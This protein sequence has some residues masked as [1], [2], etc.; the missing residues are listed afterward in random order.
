MPSLPVLLAW[1]FVLMLLLYAYP[2]NNFLFRT[3]FLVSIFL[4][5]FCLW[6]VLWKRKLLFWIV[7]I[8]L[9]SYWSILVF[10]SKSEKSTL[11][12][13][14]YL[15]QIASFEWTRYVWWGENI[16]G[17]D[18][19]GLPRKSRILAHRNIGFREFDGKH[20]MKALSLWWND[21]SAGKLL[22]DTLITEQV[23]SGKS[24]NSL[25]IKSI[26]PGDFAVTTD[27]IH[28]LVYLGKSTWIEADP[29]AWKVIKVSVPS[30]NYWFWVPVM[31]KRWRH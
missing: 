27:G 11:V 16:I 4:F 21:T 26:L 5:F 2:I 9:F 7:A 3:S 18:C 1:L 12:Q 8:T 10:W 31:V 23:T 19:S 15:Q 14:E 6:V 17:I 29:N 24:I 28:V 25:D 22:T 20:L 13:H 30:K